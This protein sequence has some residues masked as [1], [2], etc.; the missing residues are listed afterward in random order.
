MAICATSA[1]RSM[2]WHNGISAE[3]CRVTKTRD[4]KTLQALL[5][6]AI[7]G[8]GQTLELQ[9]MG[10]ILGD[11]AATEHHLKWVIYQDRRG[12]SRALQMDD[13]HVF[14][15]PI[16]MISRRVD[17]GLSVDVAALYEKAINE[18]RSDLEQRH[19]PEPLIR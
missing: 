14:L 12:R 3:V 10:V 1:T 5:D 18:I 7:V 6:R 19:L 17:V 15:F 2:P 4:L 8:S 9:A 11:L 13:R 16:T